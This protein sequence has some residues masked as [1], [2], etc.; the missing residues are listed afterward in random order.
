MRIVSSFLSP[1]IPAPTISHAF[2]RSKSVSGKKVRGDLGWA[3]AAIVGGEEKEKVV[4]VMGATGSG[5]SR[6]S[7][8]LATRYFTAAEVINSDKIQVYKGL[9][10]TTNK[11]TMPERRG[12]EHHLIGEFEASESRPEFSAA[13][14]RAAGAE[15][16]SDIVGR[17][18]VPFI[19]GG[20]NS[21]IYALLVERF[22]PELDVF[23]DECNSVGDSF[24]L[25]LRYR[26]CFLW[27]DVSPPVLNR[28]LYKRVDEM[29][30][31]GMLEE[32]SRWYS[33]PSNPLSRTGLAK[34]IGVPEFAAYFRAPRGG[35]RRERLY[36]EAVRE[37]K[38]NTRLL[39]ERQLRKI[40]RLREVGGW[41]MHRINATAAFAAA[42]GSESESETAEI[43]ENQVVQPSMKIVEKFLL[44]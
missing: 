14:F 12:V 2:L 27:V 24:G 11:I 20:S 39:A 9:D 40:Q 4:V 35:E 22:N 36:A 7:V 1:A 33:D 19:V 18:K 42:M 26:C 13:D 5:K 34:A 37:I 28:Y 29:M 21:Y 44:E 23:D 38:E 16:I 25:E 17:G 15:R 41:E 32:L 31:S 8:D 6:A 43:W 3:R 30:D 10:I